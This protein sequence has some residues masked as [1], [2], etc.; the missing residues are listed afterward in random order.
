[1][2]DVVKESH[3]MLSPEMFAALGA[4]SLAYVK[5]ALIDDEPG[6][7]IH[8]ADGRLLGAA[9]TRELAFSAARQHDLN[10]VS[11]H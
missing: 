11:V 2:N 1:M 7:L 3:I 6:F 8:G 10:P 4:P 5:A 9:P